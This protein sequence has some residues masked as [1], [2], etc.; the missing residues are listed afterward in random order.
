MVRFDDS[1][2]GY[3]NHRKQG[4]GKNGGRARYPESEEAEESWGRSLYLWGKFSVAIM[5]T[6]GEE[7]LELA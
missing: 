6:V 4:L 7:L 3:Q 2:A 1:D 5:L